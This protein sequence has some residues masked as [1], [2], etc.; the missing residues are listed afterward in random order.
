MAL[1]GNPPSEEEFEEWLN[2]PDKSKPLSAK[3]TVDKATEEV[4]K[5]LSSQKP[6]RSTTPS[7]C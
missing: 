7:L 6:F 3:K 4:R 2:R 1:P 5:A